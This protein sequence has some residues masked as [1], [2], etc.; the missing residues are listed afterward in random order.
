MYLAIRE[1]IVLLELRR[2]SSLLHLLIEVEGNIG[3]LLLDVTDDFTLGGGGERVATLSQ[4]LH[5][6]VS[7]ITTSEIETQDGV[8]ESVT[9][10]ERARRTG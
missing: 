9:L 8:G 2:L 4:D 1:L 3:Q 10:Q 6:V 5:E 7:Q